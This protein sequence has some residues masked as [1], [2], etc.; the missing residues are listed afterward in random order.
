MGGYEMGLEVALRLAE[1]LDKKPRVAQSNARAGH[2]VELMVVGRVQEALKQAIQERSQVPIIWM[3]QVAQE[4]I[5][6]IDRS[7]H[8]LYSAD[9]HPACPNSVIEALACGLPVLSFDTGALPELVSADCGRIVSYAGNAWS[10]EP[11]DIPALIEAG[12]EL[13]D[14][15]EALRRKAR[16][17]AEQ[18]FGL[19]KMVEKYLQVLLD[20]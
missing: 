13:F 5:P 7:A 11:P 20:A 18:A 14:D 1:G 17:H 4:R 9:I 15:Q 2:P 10:L 6:E 3:G 19:E 8:L 16:Q 12:L